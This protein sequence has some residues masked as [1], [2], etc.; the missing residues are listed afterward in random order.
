MKLVDLLGDELPVNAHGNIEV[1]R[2]EV[3]SRACKPDTLFFAMP[4]RNADGVHFIDDAVRN[5]AVAVIATSTVSSTVPSFVVSPAQQQALLQLASA[6]VAGNP[7]VGIQFVGV[8]GTNGKTSVATL[9]GELWQSLGMSAATIGTLTSARTTPAPPELFRTLASIRN[10]WGPQTTRP[11]VSMEVSSHA[12]DQHRV[13]ALR[14]SVAIFTNLSQDHL[15]Y[16]GSMDSYYEAKRELFESSH[17]DTAVVWVGDHYGARLADELSIPVTRVNRDEAVNARLHRDGTSFEWRGH[18]I[19]SPLIGDFNIDN[20]LLVLSAGSILGVSAA[21][22]AL[23]FRTVARVSGR[24]E[25]VSDNGPTVVV[26]YAHTPDALRRLITSARELAG[27]G[28]VIV[29]FGCGGERDHA[30]RPAM[31]SIATSLA[32]VVVLT[33]DNP[34]SE[35][36]EMILDEIEGGCEP[37]STYFR[38]SDRR[39]AIAVA[40][41]VALPHDVVLVAG[42]GHERTQIIGD[43]VIDFDDRVVI[44]ELL[45]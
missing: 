14:F 38:E 39:E 36:T 32:D 17:S 16:H 5:G 35:S 1:R 27:K 45:A 20:A 37:E 10:Q 13:D 2:V 15:D 25:I 12:I 21:D 26:D 22:M 8:T 4:G 9:M 28:R 41:N 19:E 3:D 40:L 31:G 11:L 23:A 6:R 44:R 24:F 7:E 42:K 29:V 43:S 34:R 33:S 18:N 30:K